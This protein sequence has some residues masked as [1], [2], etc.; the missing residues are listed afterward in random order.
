MT[1][2]GYVGGVLFAQFVENLTISNNIFNNSLCFSTAAGFLIQQSQQ[3]IINNNNMTNGYSHLGAGAFMLDSVNSI[4]ILDNN[5]ENN[6]CLTVGGAFLINQCANIYL[7]GN[8]YSNNQGNSIGGAGLLQYDKNIYIQNETYQ[9]NISC[10]YGAGLMAISSSNLTIINVKFDYNYSTSSTAALNLSNLL[11]LQVLV[12]NCIFTNNW[13]SDTGALRSIQNTDVLIEDSIFENNTAGLSGGAI[14]SLFGTSL[15]IKNSVF[16]QNKASLIGGVGYISDLQYLE[17]QQTQIL[18]NQAENHA[19]AFLI[20]NIEQFILN[21][22]KIE[23]NVAKDFGGGLYLNTIQDVQIQNSEFYLNKVEQ[24]S[25]S[26]NG[27]GGAL[28]IVNIEK[29]TQNLNIF[30]GNY[31]TQLGGAIYQYDTNKVQFKNLIFK[32]NSVYYEQVENREEKDRFQK[33]TQGGAIFIKIVDSDTNMNFKN[34]SFYNNKASSGTSLFIQQQNQNL[35][36]TNFKDIKIQDDVGDLGLIRYL[37]PQNSLIQEKILLSNQEKASSQNFLIVYPQ[38]IIMTNYASNEVLIENQQY[39]Y[40]LCLQGSV[41]ETGGEQKCLECQKNGVCP[42]GYLLNY[43]KTGY[44][45]ESQEKFEYIECDNKLKLCL[46][47][48]KCKQG[49]TGVLCQLCDYKNQYNRSLD[50]KCSKCP[51]IGITV[52]ISLIFFSIYFIIIVVSYQK[53]L[54]RTLQQNLKIYV[55]KL[56]GILISNEDLITS[57]TKIII[58]HYQILSMITP[59]NLNIPSFIQNIISLFSSKSYSVYDAYIECDSDQY[60]NSVLPVNLTSLTILAILLTVPNYL[61]KYKLT[62]IKHMKF[63]KNYKFYQKILQKIIA[64]EKAKQNWSK[65]K[66]FILFYK[67]QKKDKKLAIF[68]PQLILENLNNPILL[69]NLEKRH[70]QTTNM[71]LFMKATGNLVGQTFQSKSEIYQYGF[72]KGMQY[73][74]KIYD[75]KQYNQEKS[76]DFS[77]LENMVKTK[78]DSFILK[79]PAKNTK[80]SLELNFLRNKQTSIKKSKFPNLPKFNH[81]Q[82]ISCSKIFFNQEIPL[83]NSKGNFSY[84]AANFPENQESYKY[85]SD[86]STQNSPNSAEIKPEI[87]KSKSDS[88]Y[89]ENINN[90]S[91]DYNEDLIEKNSNHQIKYLENM[92]KQNSFSSEGNQDQDLKEKTDLQEKPVQIQK[93]LFID[94]KNSDFNLIGKKSNDI[95]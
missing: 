27:L 50:G 63:L 30:N 14:Q 37:G 33:I 53:S 6:T 61:E 11:T 43:P 12:K 85:Q 71:L 31:A 17:I 70:F 60:K 2:T 79:N 42:G 38:K 94:S 67:Q 24:N 73:L 5:F 16:S 49:F 28:Y 83:K 88:L 59:E 22:S 25:Y 18:N 55:Q 35:E 66:N 15:K 26:E 7:K 46:G 62:I 52:F 77:L 81:L 36:I 64:Q 4:T 23:N 91:E 39:Q 87:S 89:L 93:F 47:N 29:I 57:I 74:Q 41:L 1:A 95:N 8:F 80:K 92:N 69:H 65:L 58:M 45:R 44:W 78:N 10:D 84:Q 82:E 20:Q 48:D 3:I 90:Y 13:G 40:E 76:D 56:W 21:D 32:N 86:R 75:Q 19:G 72:N 34:I 51:S 54:S 68:E 9:E